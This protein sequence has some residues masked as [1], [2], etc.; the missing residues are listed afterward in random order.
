[1]HATDIHLHTQ[2]RLQERDISSIHIWAMEIHCQALRVIPVAKYGIVRNHHYVVTVNSLTKIGKGIFDP[3]E[4]IV[5]GKND[6]KDTYYV[7]ARI[8][9]LS[10]KIVN[11]NV[12]L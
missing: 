6:E 5:P 7:G 4:E 10:W 8:N 12:N 11:Q 9:I 3:E 2:H 1:M